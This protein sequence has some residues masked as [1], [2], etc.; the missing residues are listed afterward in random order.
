M[1][2]GEMEMDGK[3]IVVAMKREGSDFLHYCTSC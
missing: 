1:D 2:D 3:T